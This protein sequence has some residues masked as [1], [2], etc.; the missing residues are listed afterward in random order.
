MRELYEFIKLRECNIKLFYAV[1]ASV[2]LCAVMFEAC[3]KFL[4]FEIKYNLHEIS[5]IIKCL[6]VKSQNLH[7]S[8]EI[9]N[10]ITV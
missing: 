6:H 4:L 5:R 8:L 2:N 9:F 3:Q 10:V 7:S 1:S